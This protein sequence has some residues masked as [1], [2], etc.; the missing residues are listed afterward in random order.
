MPRDDDTPICGSSKIACYNAAEDDLLHE[1]YMLGIAGNSDD[2]QHECNCLPSC[3]SIRYDAETSQAPF[4][5][6]RLKKAYNITDKH[7][8]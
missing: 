7:H 8:G 4:D 2:N 6:D 5:W 3:T 1:Q